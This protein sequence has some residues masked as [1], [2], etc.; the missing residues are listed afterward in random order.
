MLSRSPYLRLGTYRLA[1]GGGVQA[2]VEEGATVFRL[3]PPAQGLLD[4][5]V[6]GQ[7]DLKLVCIHERQVSIL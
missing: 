7:I 4:S 5:G 1:L 6:E 2:T 3:G